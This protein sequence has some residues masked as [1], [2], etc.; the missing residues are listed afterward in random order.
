MLERRRMEAAIVERDRVAAHILRAERVARR[1][2]RPR[3]RVRA[4]IRTLLLG[5][6]ARYRRRGVFPKNRDFPGRAMPYFVDADGT[7]CAMAHLLE[8]GGA[9]TLVERV[10]RDNNN[11]F[12]RE[13]AG[14]AELLAWLDAA[15]ISVEEAAAIQPGYCDVPAKNICGG[16]FQTRVVNAPGVVEVKPNGDGTGT[17]VAVYGDALGVKVG[18]A[19]IA[20]GSS[21]AKALLVPIQRE[22]FQRAK[23]GTPVLG[24]GISID[25]NGI[26]QESGDHP[27][28]R[29]EVV[30]AVTKPS[31]EDCRQYVASIDAWY[32]EKEE[33]DDG[34]SASA[35]SFHPAEA[36]SAASVAIL[37]ALVS[38]IVS[39]R[40]TQRG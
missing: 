37:L 27:L 5:E 16:T 24:Q 6:L 1:A 4:L 18:E 8:L 33:C 10:A 9:A 40:R 20:G 11:A 12:V 30:T 26:L 17:V 13:L 38:A 28:T 31:Q 3:D 36:S 25:T 2:R 7:R 23:E 19:V 14:D 22:G 29:D 39:R 15:G 32:A 21:N 35:C 34:M